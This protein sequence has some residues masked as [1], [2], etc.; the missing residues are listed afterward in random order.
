MFAFQRR[1]I[2]GYRL[3][4]SVGA[5]AVVIG[6]LVATGG[7]TTFVHVPSAMFVFG[8]TCALLLGSFGKDFLKFIPDSL[9]TLFSSPPAPVPRFAEIA[10]FGGRYAVGAGVIA[11]IIGTVQTLRNV[12]DLR[13]IGIGL[14]TALISIF[15]AS[16]A[17]QI[18]FALMYKAYSDGDKTETAPH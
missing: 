10:R 15:Y 4:A 6:A 12:T 5:A 11:V 13:I 3:V 18:F 8:L 1:K 2:S 17:S 7:I 9:L 14:G 16:L